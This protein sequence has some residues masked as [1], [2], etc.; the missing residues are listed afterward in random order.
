MELSGAYVIPARPEAVWAALNDPEKLKPAIPGCEELK[1]ISDT[2]FE[3][4]ATQSIGPVKAR[5]KGKVRLKDLDPPHAYTIRGE[6]SG[7]AAGF[8]KGEA[9][10]QLAPEGA[11]TKLTYT[12]K[13]TVGGKIA[14]IG[15]RLIDGVAKKLADEFFDKFSSQF[16]EAVAVDEKTGAPLPPK[17][18]GLP[19]WVWATGVVLLIAALI[20]GLMA[21]Q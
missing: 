13:A 6:G 1:K 4:T 20:A 2:E 14:Q 11:G 18:E 21:L 5:F 16:G 19:S 9:R 3:A 12:V 7:G 17:P 8:A 10:V 15:Q